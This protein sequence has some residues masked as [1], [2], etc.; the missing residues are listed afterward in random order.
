MHSGKTQPRCWKDL[1]HVCPSFFPV[2]KKTKQFG[3]CFKWHVL[4]CLREI[5]N[6]EFASVQCLSTTSWGVPQPALSHDCSY[7]GWE[8]FSPP[9]ERKPFPSS[10]T[11]HD[12][13]VEWISWLVRVPLLMADRHAYSQVIILAEA[14]CTVQIIFQEKD[15]QGVIACLDSFLQEEKSLSLSLSLG[16][17]P[18]WKKNS[19]LWGKTILQNANTANSISACL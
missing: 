11:A 18:L 16:Y 7:R 5:I 14:S 9:L 15:S 4:P 19:S 6:A 17:R 10:R 3:P 12:E 8:D 1:G 13:D 2:Q